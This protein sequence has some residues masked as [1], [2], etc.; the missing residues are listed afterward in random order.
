MSEEVEAVQVTAIDWHV[1][2]VQGQSRS[3]IKEDKE[4][5]ESVCTDTEATNTTGNTVEK[6]GWWANR[7]FYFHTLLRG[8]TNHPV[9]NLVLLT[10]GTR[11]QLKE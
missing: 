6:G 2:D 7:D 9:G 10:L 3:K 8:L 11:S 1:K 4:M 5:K